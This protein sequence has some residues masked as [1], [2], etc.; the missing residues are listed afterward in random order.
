M[1]LS[2]SD[3]QEQQVSLCSDVKAIR[4]IDDGDGERR[5]NM[6][7]E[8]GMSTQWRLR[9]HASRGM[10]VAATSVLC[11]AQNSQQA[12]QLR[13][14]RNPC[15]VLRVCYEDV[16]SLCTYTIWYRTKARSAG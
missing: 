5:E 2:L 15:S 16:M 13:R 11:N 3:M 4:I 9:R 6:C 7:V 14:R 12:S 1:V 10:S 8:M